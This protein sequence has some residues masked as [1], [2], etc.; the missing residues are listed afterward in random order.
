MLTST[1]LPSSITRDASRNWKYKSTGWKWLRLPWEEKGL[2]SPGRSL[3]TFSN[4]SLGSL[5]VWE[6]TLSMKALSGSTLASGPLFSKVYRGGGKGRELEEEGKTAY[7]V[8]STCSSLQPLTDILS[9]LM[10]FQ[11][12]IGFDSCPCNLESSSKGRYCN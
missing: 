12:L 9:M 6:T 4:L 1:L 11:K 7:P 2:I 5:Q 8:E 3:Q 10:I